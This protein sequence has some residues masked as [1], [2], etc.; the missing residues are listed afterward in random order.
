MAS[1]PSEEVPLAIQV[2]LWEQ[3][4]RVLAV[5]HNLWRSRTLPEDSPL[6]P[7]ARQAI[8]SWFLF[9]GTPVLVGGGLMAL[10]VAWLT[11]REMTHQTAAIDE[12]TAAVIEQTK[13]ATE[14]LREMT[15]QTKALVAQNKLLMKEARSAALR[16]HTAI[17]IDAS[18]HPAVKTHSTLQVLDL[19]NHLGVPADLRGAQ[20]RE[21]RLIDAD[22]RRARLA[23]AVLQEA[24]LAGAD[25][26][27]ADLTGANLSHAD[28]SGAD[29][30]DARL[31]GCW[32]S[33]ANL[34]AARFDRTSFDERTRLH[35]AYWSA[36]SP[37]LN[38]PPALEQRLIHARPMRGQEHM[39]QL[40]TERK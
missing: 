20:T 31:D 7:A 37:P 30:S 12:Q 13:A 21:L 5:I 40:P 11:Y 2:K 10:L 38:A 9:G 23:Q 34:T 28:L 27:G 26:R 29:L 1:D 14:Q 22:L 24:N 35:G 39:L 32:L 16:R 25:L 4:H 33:W 17:V 6:R 8:I 15:E 3:E 19:S 36:E 18:S